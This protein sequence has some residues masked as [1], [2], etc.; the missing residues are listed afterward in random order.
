M[1]SLVNF[2]VYLINQ[3]DPDKQE[4][5]RFGVDQDVVT[6]FLYLRE[7]ILSVFPTLRGRHFTI[8]WR[9]EDKDDIVISSDEEWGIALGETADDLVRKL[10]VF[11]YSEYPKDYINPSRG[12]SGVIHD[13]VVCDGCEK[14]I[15]GFRYKCLQCPDFDLCANCDARGIHEDH[16]M[17]RLIAPAQWKPHWG[18]RIAGLMNRS[19]RKASN[20]ADDDKELK[21]PFTRVNSCKEDRRDKEHCRNKDNHH[22]GNGKDKDKQHYGKQHKR[23]CNDNNGVSWTN[24]LASYL[25]DWANVPGE[26]PSMEKIHQDMAKQAATAAST[27]ASSASAASAGAAAGAA[28]AVADLTGTIPKKNTTEEPSV[29]IPKTKSTDDEQKS[30]DTASKDDKQKSEKKNPMDPYMELLKMVGENFTPFIETFVNP[31]P[32]V[33]GG[34]S[35]IQKA[36]ADAAAAAVASH[37]NAQPNPYGFK[38]MNP[39]SKDTETTKKTD[40]ITTKVTENITPM[41]TDQNNNASVETPGADKSSDNED[42]TI[43][44][45][46]AN[47][48]TVDVDTSKAIPLPY[49]LAEEKASTSTGLY[50]KLPHIEKVQEA[51]ETIIYHSDKKIQ[52]SIETMMEMGFTNEGGWLTNLLVSKDGDI[53]SALDT[54]SPVRR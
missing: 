49:K 28:A 47:P 4:I 44:G 10:Y 11:V 2:K 23:R 19:M 29:K 5:R 41:D 13:G 40:P 9:D 38:L 36:A 30:N 50:P 7:K 8:S 14:Q 24:T 1:T 31:Q 34:M 27:A 12:T 16:C 20:A 54:L 32:Q 18:R 3:E 6:N 35:H 22:G 21:C 39:K 17:L 37:F 25:N 26:C 48:S 42:W 33:S 15:Q 46:N 53:A 51:K 43:I 52:Q 45:A